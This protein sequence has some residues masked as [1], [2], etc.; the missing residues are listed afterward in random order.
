MDWNNVVSAVATDEGLLVTERGADGQVGAPPRLMPY[1]QATTSLPG[2]MVTPPPK[3]LTK[4]PTYRNAQCWRWIKNPN[5]TGP[6]VVE[7]HPAYTQWSCA[8]SPPFQSTTEPPL[9]TGYTIQPETIQPYSQQVCNKL[10]RLDGSNWTAIK[11]TCPK[12][13]IKPYE[14]QQPTPYPAGRPLS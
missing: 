13:L 3:L 5:Y 7:L 6:S 4:P 2:R 10:E 8:T 12:I 14:L 9:L 1:P 11:S